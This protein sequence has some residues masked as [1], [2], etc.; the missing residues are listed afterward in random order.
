MKASS[1]A[2]PAF[3]HRLRRAVMAY[4]SSAEIEDFTR[5]AVELEVPN[6]S[7]STNLMRL[8]ALGYVQLRRGFLGRKPRTSVVLTSAGRTAWALYLDRLSL[9]G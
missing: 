4:L 8:E 5:L 7:L 9:K 3:S 6:N 1:D 2:D